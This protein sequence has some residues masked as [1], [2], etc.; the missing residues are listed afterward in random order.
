MPTGDVIDPSRDGSASLPATKHERLR[1]ALLELIERDP[2]REQALPSER[3]L[4]TEYGVSRM[5]ARAAI[6]ELADQ[7]FVYRVQGRGTFVRQPWVSKSLALTSFTED[8]LARGH[9]PGTRV[10]VC[11][12]RPAGAA[13]GRDLSISPADPVIFVRRVRLADGVPICLESVELPTRL[14]PGLDRE[15]LTASLYDLLASRYRIRITHAE[16][17]IRATV[18][19]QEEAELLGVPPVS[20]ALLVERVS[21]DRAGRPVERAHSLYRSDRYDFRVAVDRRLPDR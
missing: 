15:K 18:L 13:A 1:S 7:G 2:R 8:M 4:A 19:D 5:T 11:A 10:V 16:Q 17:R 21:T 9:R 3:D 6:E 20:P 12:E 14:V